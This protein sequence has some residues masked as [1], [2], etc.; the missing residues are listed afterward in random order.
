MN[1]FAAALRR[2]LAPLKAIHCRGAEAISPRWM[3][4][5]WLIPAALGLFGGYAA[6]TKAPGLVCALAGLACAWQ[7]WREATGRTI[8]VPSPRWPQ[9]RTRG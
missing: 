2:V 9:R 8:D 5:L 4:A 1:A 7:W 3:T 6:P